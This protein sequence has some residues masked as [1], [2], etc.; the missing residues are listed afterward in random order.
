MSD[1]E[2]IMST[3]K[4]T[5]DKF[6]GRTIEPALEVEMVDALMAALPK[7]LAVRSHWSRFCADYCAMKKT[8]ESSVREVLAR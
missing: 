1:Y 5:L 3:V 7:T 4:E 2:E 8:A 6:E